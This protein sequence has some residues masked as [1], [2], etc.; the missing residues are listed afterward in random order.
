MLRRW[1]RLSTCWWL[2]KVF[3]ACRS[4]VMVERIRLTGM[5]SAKSWVVRLNT[6]AVATRWTCREEGWLFMVPS[7]SCKKINQKK[8]TN[9]IVPAQW[10]NLRKGLDDTFYCIFCPPQKKNLKKVWCLLQHIIF[11]LQEIVSVS[12]LERE[13]PDILNNSRN[14]KLNFSFHNLHKV[15]RNTGYLGWRWK[16][17]WDFLSTFVEYIHHLWFSKRILKLV[18]PLNALLSLCLNPI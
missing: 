18:I 17:F 9:M 8:K 11:R 4:W 7:T 16:P 3:M 10:N 6:H 13:K 2:G 14:S 1:G 15:F 5:A 12:G